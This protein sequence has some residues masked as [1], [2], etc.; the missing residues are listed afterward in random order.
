MNHNQYHADTSRISKSGTDKIN[1]SPA[2]YY[3]HYLDPE[4]VKAEPTPAMQ[5]GTLIHTV[6]LEP[7]KLAAE[8]AVLPPGAPSRDCLRHRNAKNPSEETIKNIAWWDEWLANNEGKQIL[9]AKQYNKAQRITDSVRRH[10]AAAWLLERPGIV[11]TPH[12]WQDLYTGAPCKCMPDKRLHKDNILVDVK[13]TEDAGPDGFSKSVVNYRYD[14][15]GAYYLDGFDHGAN[16]IRHDDF[17]FIAVEKEPPFAVGVY[18]LPEEAIK[19]GREKY[20]RNLHTYMECL[21]TG[22][23]PAYSD[24]CIDL[25]MPK[26]YFK[27]F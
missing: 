6:I 25:S 4:R 7:H 12:T 5:E 19:V 13:S 22:N 3:A 1:R 16:P 27:Q 9:D 20:L 11:E 23:W 21:R 14:V 26:Y 10:P 8:Y 2:H 17:I 18:R 24:E 15:Q